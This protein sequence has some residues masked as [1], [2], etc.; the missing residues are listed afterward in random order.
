MSFLNY[1]DSKKVVDHLG[2]DSVLYEMTCIVEKRLSTLRELTQTCSQ[3][4]GSVRGVGERTKRSIYQALM[5]NCREE[6]GKVNLD[7]DNVYDRAILNLAKEHDML[8]KALDEKTGEMYMT[9]KPEY[10]E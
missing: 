6:L 2:M 10:K 7:S 9:L 8:Y 5:R 3:I 4:R 1:E